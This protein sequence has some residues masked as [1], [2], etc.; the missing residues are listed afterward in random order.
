MFLLVPVLSVS[1]VLFLVASVCLAFLLT[2]C[3]CFPV[4]LSCA[5]F[6]AF[7]VFSF[8]QPLWFL[9]VPCSVVRLVCAGLLLSACF[10]ATLHDRTVSFIVSLE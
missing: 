6:F 9:P 3:L 5:S 2:Q 10:S 7:A 1:F 8:P 4:L